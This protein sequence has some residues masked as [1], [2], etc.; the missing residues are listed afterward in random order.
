MGQK[1]VG[2]IYKVNVVGCTV[3]VFDMRNE[4]DFSQVL[5]KVNKIILSGF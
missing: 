1:L 5:W 2:K 3:S 4:L